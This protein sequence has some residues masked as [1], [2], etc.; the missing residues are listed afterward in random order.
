MGYV[1]VQ[2]IQGALSMSEYPKVTISVSEYPKIMRHG[3]GGVV[4]KFT[5]Y[6]IG[7]VIGTG[8][9]GNDEQVVGY[10]STD[11]YMQVFIPYRVE[12]LETKE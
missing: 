8:H 6:G 5:E 2:T 10:H 7:T 9:I 1:A 11:W 12:I 4:V 3:T